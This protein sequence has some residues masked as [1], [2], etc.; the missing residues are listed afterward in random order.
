[1]TQ[2]IL[3]IC[4]VSLQLFFNVPFE[5]LSGVKVSRQFFY[6][7]YILY[8]VKSWVAEFWIGI[9]RRERSVGRNCGWQLVHFSDRNQMEKVDYESESNVF[10]ICGQHELLLRT[11]FKFKKSNIFCAYIEAKLKKASLLWKDLVYLM[12]LNISATVKKYW[13]Y[14]SYQ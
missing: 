8:L 7:H 10:K 11:G 12:F 3:K 14:F 2:Y 1:M 5:K 13:R 9:Q 6:D 4:A